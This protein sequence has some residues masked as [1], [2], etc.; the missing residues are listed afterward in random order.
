MKKINLF[1]RLNELEGKVD[2]LDKHTLSKDARE[3]LE[4]RIDAIDKQNFKDVGER[5]KRINAITD[6][7]KIE[8]KEEAVKDE[9]Y[10]TPMP[11]MKLLGYD[12][13]DD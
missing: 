1:G 3:G 4:T 11:R 7:L 12:P 9:S 8:F 10:P 13:E 6:Y 5:A 2:Y